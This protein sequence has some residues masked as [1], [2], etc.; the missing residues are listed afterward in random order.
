MDRSVL[1]CH[2]ELRLSLD[3]LPQTVQLHPAEERP[4]IHQLDPSDEED[5]SPRRRS[6]Y[7]EYFNS[8]SAQPC[9]PSMDSFLTEQARNGRAFGSLASHF[10]V[11]IPS[12]AAL[13][14]SE[15]AGEDHVFSS[16]D[17][18]HRRHRHVPRDRERP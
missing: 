16:G 15:G 3:V 18:D 13:G 14:V 1:T 5:S 11:T 10:N 8:D 4:V 17:K 6:P 12:S 2:V 9:F 7:V